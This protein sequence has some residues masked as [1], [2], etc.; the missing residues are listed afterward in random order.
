MSQQGGN[1]FN[2]VQ[3]LVVN[4]CTRVSINNT[5]IYQPFA[6]L[7]PKSAFSNAL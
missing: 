4:K 5:P 3:Y 7:S 6:V 2:Q 1:T